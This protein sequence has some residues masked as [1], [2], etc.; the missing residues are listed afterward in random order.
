MKKTLTIMAIFVGFLASVFFAPVLFPVVSYIIAII[1]T[2]FITIGL[3]AMAFIGPLL[4]LGVW[5]IGVLAVIGV[6]VFVC[7]LIHRA[8]PRNRVIRLN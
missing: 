1:I 2:I 6:V 7:K 3:I 4:Y 8:Q 5:A